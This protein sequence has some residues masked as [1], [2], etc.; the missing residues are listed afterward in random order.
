MVLRKKFVVVICAVDTCG[1]VKQC[2][3]AESFNIR[4]VCTFRSDVLVER[5]HS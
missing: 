3:C 4:P 5:V 2:Y 1:V